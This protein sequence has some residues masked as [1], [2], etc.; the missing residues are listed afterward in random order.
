MEENH[1]GEHKVE[2]ADHEWKNVDDCHFKS[3]EKLDTVP[4]E[5]WHESWSDKNPED[6]HNG[7]V[8]AHG[9]L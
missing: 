5:C 7:K 6:W 1:L 2:D 4:V 9:D 3:E 8:E